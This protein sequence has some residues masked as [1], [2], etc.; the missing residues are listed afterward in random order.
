M[1]RRRIV[2]MD[3]G[4]GFITT[5]ML[6]SIR[7]GLAPENRGRF[8][9]EA[10]LLAGT[11]GGGINALF[12][13]SHA[14]PDAALDDA[15]SFWQTAYDTMA[16]R[17][18]SSIPRTLGA[19]VG[20]NAANSRRVLE[21]FLIQYFGANTRLGDL[22]RRVLITSFQLD[23]G[24]ASHRR[25]A[26]RLFGNFDGDHPDMEEL[27]VDV[28]L[29]TSG[30]P[31]VL[32]IFQSITRQGSG[33]IDGGVFANNPAMCAV[34]Q[35]LGGSPGEVGLGDLVLLSTGNGA[36]ERYVAPT[37]R[38]GTANWGYDAWMLDPGRPLLLLDAVLQADGLVVDYQCR[39]LLAERYH[40]IDPVL[41]GVRMLLG[42]D[43]SRILAGVMA[44]PGTGAQIAETT[45]WTNATWWPLQAE[46]EPHTEL[47]SPVETVS[48]AVETQTLSVDMQSQ[49]VST[50]PSES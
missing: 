36:E 4:D 47:E 38:R 31:I 6:R 32:P 3:G 23:D 43:V 1:A 7:D 13:A 14:D 18:S 33:Y 34:A 46:S 28:A 29:R 35:A 11:S 24:S 48:V 19:L 5:G 16:F 8:L 49:V 50:S 15:L 17:Y 37:Y 44:L 21:D 22:R 40:R 41:P 25:W 45:A 42:S 30:V 20:L 9:N 12:L 27:V 10:D 2:A 39:T 26:P